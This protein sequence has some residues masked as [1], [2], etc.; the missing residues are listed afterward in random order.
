MSAI[1]GGAGRVGRCRAGRHTVSGVDGDL[2]G[3]A[4]AALRRLVGRDDVD[5][6]DGQLEAI[7]ALV[8]RVRACSSSSARVGQVGGLFRGDRAAAGNGRRADDHRLA[9]AGPH[10]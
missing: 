4:R 2:E 6:R 3:N 9:A 10:A 5:F 7:S 1:S 8:D